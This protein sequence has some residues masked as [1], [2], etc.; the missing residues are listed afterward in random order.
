MW[1]DYN[2]SNDSLFHCP[3]LIMASLLVVALLAV[4]Y[5]NINQAAVIDGTLRQ[6]LRILNSQI[7]VLDSLLD[8]NCPSYVRSKREESTDSLYAELD[9]KALHYQLL[10]RQYIE[11]KLETGI[12][13][14]KYTNP[15]LS[16]KRPQRSIT[17]V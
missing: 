7:I 13:G 2:P 9:V 14:N 1:C 4:F 15:I 3:T 12:A 16:G 6:Q 8:S 10:K 5:L 11:C 17:Y